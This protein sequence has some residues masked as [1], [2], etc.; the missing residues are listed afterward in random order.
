MSDADK[1]IEELIRA[2]VHTALMATPML[3]AV[4]DTADRTTQAVVEAL[5]WPKR[6]QDPERQGSGWLFVAQGVHLV[7]GYMRAYTTDTDVAW[8]VFTEVAREQD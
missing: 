6:P 2:A 4:T 5:Q 3:Q 7:T 8:E 1:Q